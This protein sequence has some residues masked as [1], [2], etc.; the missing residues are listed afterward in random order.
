MTKLQDFF[1]E[2]ALK[3][4]RS[5]FRSFNRYVAQVSSIQTKGRIPLIDG[6]I[7]LIVADHK[8]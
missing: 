7:Y 3:Q 1:S 6:C 4:S 8:R 2:G 5:G